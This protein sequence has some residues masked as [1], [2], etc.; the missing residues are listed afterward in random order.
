MHI[1]PTPFI[2]S[3]IWKCSPWSR[4]LKF[5]SPEFNTHG[6]LLVSKLFPYTL[7]ISHNTSLQTDGQ[8]DD[9]HA[10]SS[11]VTKVRLANKKK[12][13]D[14]QT[15]REIGRLTEREEGMPWLEQREYTSPDVPHHNKVLAVVCVMF[16]AERQ[17]I[18]YHRQRFTGHRVIYERHT[19]RVSQTTHADIYTCISEENHNRC[20]NFKRNHKILIIFGTYIP[21]TTGHQMHTKCCFYLVLVD[22]VS[23]WWC[24]A[25]TMLGSWYIEN[26][27][28]IETTSCDCA[29]I[30]HTNHHSFTMTTTVTTIATTN[31]NYC[32][33]Y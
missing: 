27:T 33:W 2:Q 22:P 31:Y 30:I 20:H 32:S 18:Q 16:H 12:Q 9:N 15:E 23:P 13:K 29:E 24:R 25:K 10:N 26:R 28:T 14:R 3:P 7:P 8:M 19:A 11:T 21:D 5:C 6:Y 17:Q 4:W 1:F